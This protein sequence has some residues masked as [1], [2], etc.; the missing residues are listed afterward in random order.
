MLATEPLLGADHHPGFHLPGSRE[1]PPVH[2]AASGGHD[3]P[4][5]VHRA[6]HQQLGEAWLARH[7]DAAV[8]A[9]LRGPGDGQAIDG[10]DAVEGS[11]PAADHHFRLRGRRC[12][13]R[14]RAQIGLLS[15]V[16]L[17]SWPPCLTCRVPVRT[18]SFFCRREASSANCASP[19]A[20]QHRLAHPQRERRA[21]TGG[22][23]QLGLAQL[24][25]L[26]RLAVSR[27]CRADRAAPDRPWR[28]ARRC[29]QGAAPPRRSSPAPGESGGSFCAPCATRLGL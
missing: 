14:A 22:S 12:G 16:Q 28:G 6:V 10:R 2:D 17:A 24:Q 8:G 19:G 25:P 1:H 18:T 9:G 20:R 5:P 27:R 29:A 13:E 7:L 11:V 3:H 21:R 4:G 26:Q 15:R 23:A